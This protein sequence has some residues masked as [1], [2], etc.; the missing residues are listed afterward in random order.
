[1]IMCVALVM[2]A[3]P[4]VIREFNERELFCGGLYVETGGD[5]WLELGKR[6]SIDE[7]IPR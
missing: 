1:M 4:R 2:N 6:I 5:S 3:I 7:V